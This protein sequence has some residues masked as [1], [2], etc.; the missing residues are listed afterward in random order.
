MRVLVS[1]AVLVAAEIT[2]LYVVGSQIGFLGLVAVLLGAALLGAWAISHEGRRSMRALTQALRSGRPAD[3]ELVDGML[4]AA[5]G[6]LLV[7]PGLISDIA[8]LVL[9]LPP[10]RRAVGRRITASATQRTPRVVAFAPAGGAGPVFGP[11]GPAAGQSWGR[12]APR[13][14]EGTVIEG[15]VLDGDADPRDHRT[16]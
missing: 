7:L 1:L 5:A 16:G 6:V 12:P 2:L 11:A 9:L 10:V 15:S 4:V 8:A 13:P 14:F 3:A